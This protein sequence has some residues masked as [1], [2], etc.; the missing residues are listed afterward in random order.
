MIFDLDHSG[1]T[2][3]GRPPNLIA[4]CHRELN[5]VHDQILII[6]LQRASAAQH[7]PGRLLWVFFRGSRTR[8]LRFV[9]NVVDLI[10]QRDRVGIS[11]LR[12]RLMSR[13]FLHQPQRRLR[14]RY[15]NDITHRMRVESLNVGHS[16]RCSP[17]C[18]RCRCPA[19]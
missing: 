12:C 8:L 2:S 7:E 9:P 17:R 16:V 4:A 3:S 1:R 11:H 6:D 15:F 18:L 14:Q 10:E 19:D 13:L 5:N